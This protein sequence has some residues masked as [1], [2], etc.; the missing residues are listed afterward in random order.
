[1][2]TGC[3]EA[4]AMAHRCGDPTLQLEMQRYR[5]FPRLGSPNPAEL[6]QILRQ[7]YEFALRTGDAFTAGLNLGSLAGTA[8]ARGDRTRVDSLLSEEFPKLAERAPSRTALQYL[9]VMRAAIALAEGRFDDAKRIAAEARDAWRDDF[10]SALLFRA[11]LQAARLERGR[12]A[13]IADV[14]S[15]FVQDAPRWLQYQRTVLVTALVELG[16]FDDARRELAAFDA[17]R[18]EPRGWA[19]PLAL[20]HL[21]E[22]SALLGDE[23]RAAELVPRLEPYA[24]L[25][26]VG[27]GY[28]VIE[29]SADRARGQM[30]ATLGRLDEAIACYESGLALEESF[31]APALAAR[32]RYWLARAL[33]TRGDAARARAEAEASRDAARGFGMILLADQ[34]EALASR[35][36]AR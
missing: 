1:M 16:R 2:V 14:L 11:Q 13:Q 19:W 31:G 3:E 18:L 6:E 36:N 8:T 29:S 10:Q 7:V 20:R 17:L 9:L 22:S 34:A 26:L 4:A 23:Q 15:G 5:V 25:L 12:H 35:L 33:A 32:T 30:L 24:G 28:T 27:Y 21:A